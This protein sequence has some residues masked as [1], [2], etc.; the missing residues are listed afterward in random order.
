MG[1]CA[2]KR[3]VFHN[4]PTVA[5]A[6]LRASPPAQ[7]WAR[8]VQSSAPQL[9]SSQHA[10]VR[11]P[12]A[13]RYLESSPILV[14]GPATG[15]Q[16]RFSRAEPVQAVDPRDAEPLARTRFFRRAAFAG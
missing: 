6:P 1:C 16:Y 10:V 15:R 5:P 9:N 4:P 13:L 12:V 7:P 2:D 8:T 14:R 3:A 11:N